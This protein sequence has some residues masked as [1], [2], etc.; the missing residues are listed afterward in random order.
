MT[1]TLNLSKV[2]QSHTL[3]LPHTAC[4]Q[5]LLHHMFRQIW[6][7]VKCPVTLVSPVGTSKDPEPSHHSV[8]ETYKNRPSK[9]SECYSGH[10]TSYHGNAR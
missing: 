3:T 5:V 2:P 6:L 9:T 8:G 4:M 1:T 10:E 7:P